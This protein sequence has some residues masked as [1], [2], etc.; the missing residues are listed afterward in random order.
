M[1]QLI[2]S[3][4]ILLLPVK[5]LYNMFQEFGRDWTINLLEG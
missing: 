3:K 5:M 4:L 1:R 2:F